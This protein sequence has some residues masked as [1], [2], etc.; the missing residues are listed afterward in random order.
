[1]KLCK[2]CKHS[3]TQKI[4]NFCKHP[5]SESGIDVVTGHQLFT[6]C[7]E[8]RADTNIDNFNDFCGKEARYWEPKEKFGFIKTWRTWLK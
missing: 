7:W 4:V 1:M 8:A 2:D 3:G 6:L 5:K